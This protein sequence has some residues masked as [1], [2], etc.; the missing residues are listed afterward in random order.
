VWTGCGFSGQHSLFMGHLFVRF[1]RALGR[2]LGLARTTM[3]TIGLRRNERTK[4]ANNGIQ[5]ARERGSQ[6]DRAKRL[7]RM[8]GLVSDGSQRKRM[9]NPSAKRGWVKMRSM[10]FNAAARR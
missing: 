9:G 7:Q 1:P 4:R 2:A 8:A 6:T 10:T 3:V 5:G